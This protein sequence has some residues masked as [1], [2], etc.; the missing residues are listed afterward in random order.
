MTND[1][2]I[3]QLD[4]YLD[5]VLGD[6]DR[7]A[8]EARLAGDVELRDELA[9]LK[10]LRSQVDALPRRVDPDRDLWPA[11]VSRLDATRRGTIDFGSYRRRQRVPIARY[12]VAAAALV[13]F[14][15]SAPV[16]INPPPDDGKPP[17]SA[18]VPV[19]ANDPEFARVTEQY[20][21]AR[22]ELL[23]LLEQRKDDIAPETYAV[24]KDNLSVISSAVSE[25]EVAIAAE[26]ESVKLE[27]ML[28][29]AYR[30]EV[31]L[32]RQA[33]QLSDGPAASNQPEAT[34][35][36]SDAV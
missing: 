34:Q 10:Q 8:L 13:L 5:G 14:A 27:R 19:L 26:P 16:W 29:A 24:I 35:G 23:T 12:L 28:H 6:A 33:V 11:I 4:D 3:Q 2:T 7:A 22:D 21:A 15:I 18:E 25:I 31:D 32:L 9:A 30:S 17:A 1:E 20:V 36:E